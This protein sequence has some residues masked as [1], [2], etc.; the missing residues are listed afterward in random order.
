MRYLR[1][2]DRLAGKGEVQARADGAKVEEKQE[3]CVLDG[4]FVRW[5]EK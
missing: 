1:E 3:V 2:R 4:G 5:Q